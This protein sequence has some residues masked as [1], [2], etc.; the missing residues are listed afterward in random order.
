M[1][2]FFLY[3][4]ET[5]N[6]ILFST[7]TNLKFL[8]SLP[9][10]SVDGTFYSA[11]KFF[12]QV[13]IVHGYQNNVSVPLAFFLLP[14][15]SVSSY[16][17]VFSILSAQCQRMLIVFQPATIYCDFESAIHIAIQ[18]ILSETKIWLSVPLRTKLVQKN[19]INWI[20]QGI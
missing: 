14:D 3:N 8:S 7:D 19:T 20:K 2:I 5:D 11:P 16:K 12:K 9:E 15:K 4:N 10:I 1:R 17:I 6:I 18:E 13:F